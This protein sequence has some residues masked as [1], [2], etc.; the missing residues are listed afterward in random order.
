MQTSA[1]ILLIIVFSSNASHAQV[2]KCGNSFSQTPCSNEAKQLSG[3][4]SKPSEPNNQHKARTENIK[5]ECDRWIRS[6]PGWKD[7]DSV[8]HDGIFRGKQEVRNIHGTPLIVVPYY[9]SVNAKNSYG[10]YAG[11]RPYV[12]YANQGETRIIDFY[13]AGDMPN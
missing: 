7:P 13:K 10:A 11:A 1:V 12:C 3:I 8:K 9:A 2:Y 4:T 6:L 5:A